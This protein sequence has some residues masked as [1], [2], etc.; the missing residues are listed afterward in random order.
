MEKD[1]SEM[2]IRHDQQIKSLEKRVAK[3]EG[4][5]ESINSLAIS[6]EKMCVV[7]ENMLREQQSLKK[8]V[9]EIKNQ[10][11]KDLHEIKQKVL[12]AV[13]T[14][15]ASSIVSVLITLLAKGGF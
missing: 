7:Q 11:V 12:I 5:T 2:V 4:T 10:P 3:C 8:D 1:K 13:A 15:I 6:V 9:E 14:M